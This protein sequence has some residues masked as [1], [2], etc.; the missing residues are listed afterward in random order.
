MAVLTPASYPNRT[1]NIFH[2]SCYCTHD[3]LYRTGEVIDRLKQNEKSDEI[4]NEKVGRLV[5]PEKAA[6][7]WQQKDRLGGGRVEGASKTHKRSLG[8]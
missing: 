3:V 2:Q 4:G 1:A 6:S 8:F 7:C 5:V